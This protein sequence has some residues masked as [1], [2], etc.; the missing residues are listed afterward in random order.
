MNRQIPSWYRLLTILGFFLFAAE[1]VPAS[2]DGYP[3]NNEPSTTVKFGDLDLNTDAGRRALL[4]RL[5]KAADRVCREQAS[6]FAGVGFSQVRLACYRR[7]LAAAVD[8][9]HHVQLSAL[10]AA[11]SRPNKR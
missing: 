5:S 7:T 3:L 11:L 4:D 1:G 9:V 2:A 10:F 6:S 8:K